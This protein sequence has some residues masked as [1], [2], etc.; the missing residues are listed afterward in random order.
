MSINSALLAGVSG[1]VAN[2]SAMAVISDNISNVN[3]TAY[4][5]N[6]TDF[7]RLVNS[8][9]RGTTYNAG[10]TTAETR[11]LVRAQGNI[12]SSSIN[13]D[14]AI[15]GEGFFVVSPAAQADSANPDILY[16]RVGT[17]KPDSEGYML[18]HTGYALR[19]WRLDADGE[20]IG[21]TSDVASLVPVNINTISNTADPSTTASINGNLNSATPVS[22]AAAAA[23]VGGAGAYNAATNNM[24]SGAVTPDA[25]WQFQ[26]IDSLGGRKTFTIGLLKSATPNQWHAEVFASPASAVVSGAPLVN[27]QIKSGTLAFTPTGIIDIAASTASL[28][29]PISIGAAAAGAPAGG[30]VNWA[31]STGLAAQ[32]FSMEIGQN[33]TASGAV[34]QFAAATGLNSTTADGSPTGELAGL[35]IDKEGFVIANFTSGLNKKIFKIPLA[36]FV[37]PDDLLAQTNGAYRT[38]A[39]SGAATLKSAGSSGAGSLKSSALEASTVDLALEFSNMIITQRA[40]SASSKIITTAD[41]MLDELIRMKR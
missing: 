12:I 33:A 10:G 29:A 25:T 16:S 21:G 26:I 28:L 13:T 39:D 30:S 5:K 36:T 17:F 34:T 18:N 6:R 41:E 4:K 23:A 8:Q 1:L 32:T 14:L 22:A 31:P 19:G 20:I 3:T 38:T 37:N 2:S 9:G 35:D 27:G 24:A 40:Y 15:Q 11:Q 7:T